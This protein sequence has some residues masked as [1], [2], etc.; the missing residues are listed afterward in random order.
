MISFEF[1]FP[2]NA[3]QGESFFFF[4]FPFLFSMSPNTRLPTEGT[5][6]IF[7]SFASEGVTSGK[8]GLLTGM[9][10]NSYLLKALL[11]HL[12]PTDCDRLYI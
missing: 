2:L 3:E 9:V 4:P 11:A 8:G 10:E 7:L 12:H 1:Q 5:R 6:R